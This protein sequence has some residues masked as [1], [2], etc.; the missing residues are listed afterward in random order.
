[1]KASNF[2][3]KDDQ[4]K[5]VEAI[6]E[7]EH[8]TSGEIR[9]HIDS[10]CKGE[11]LDAAAK[12]FA[13]LNMHKTHLRNGVLIYLA[14]EDR[15]FAII[16]DVGI[17]QKVPANF[18]D[19]IKNEMQEHFKNSEFTKGLI[20]GISMSG[21]QLKQHFPHEKD[22]KNELPDEVSFGTGK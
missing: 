11:V 1:M 6:K 21:T 22:D 15:K 4:N 19:K 14:V 2:F 17:N 7:A 20:H 12:V 13:T 16:G 3:S 9:V 18:W 8:K 5:I 10:K